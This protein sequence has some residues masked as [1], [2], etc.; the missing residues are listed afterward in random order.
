LLS[1]NVD[2]RVDFALS[3]INRLFER[4]EKIEENVNAL[5]YALS[6]LSKRIDDLER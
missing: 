3:N 6:L 1:Q 4:I 2:R 5:E